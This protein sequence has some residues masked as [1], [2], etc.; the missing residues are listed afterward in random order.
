MGSPQ[1]ATIACQN[2]PATNCNFFNLK[3]VTSQD[4]LIGLRW[5]LLP[6]PAPMVMPQ[7]PLVSRG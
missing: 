7:P 4:F 6:E 1:S 3:D 2:T 5:I